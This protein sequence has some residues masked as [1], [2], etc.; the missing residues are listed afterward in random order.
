MRPTTTSAFLR[1]GR[2]AVL[3]CLERRLAVDQQPPPLLLGKELQLTKAWRAEV[4]GDTGISG[5]RRE[6]SCGSTPT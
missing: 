2:Q 4:Q 1:A 3:R 5:R 6:A